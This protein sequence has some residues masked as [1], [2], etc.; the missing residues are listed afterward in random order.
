[1]KG[2]EAGLCALTSAVQLCDA[3]IVKE[4][5]ETLRGGEHI[6]YSSAGDLLLLYQ[7][8]LTAR[9]TKCG[10]VKV[11]GHDLGNT[12]K[13]VEYVFLYN[14]ETWL[15][16]QHDVNH[17]DDT[18]RQHLISVTTLRKKTEDFA[19]EM[20]KRPYTSLCGTCGHPQGDR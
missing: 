18:A 17:R 11:S 2:G 12:T 1:M 10:R 7:G 16:A 19:N 20:P 8:K 15:V 13:M 9:C 14:E 3:R 6:E 5:F 4:A